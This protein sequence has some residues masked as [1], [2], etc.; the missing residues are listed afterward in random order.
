MDIH[1]IRELVFAKQI[2]FTEHALDESGAARLSQSEVEESLLSGDIIEVESDARGTKYR[3]QGWTFYTRRVVES[4][5]A[6]RHDDNA[7]HDFANVI[8]VFERKSKPRGGR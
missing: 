7:D 4:I 2:R 5:V 1:T 3:V 8:T 6:V